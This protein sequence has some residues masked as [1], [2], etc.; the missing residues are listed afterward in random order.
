MKIKHKSKL[1]RISNALGYNRNLF[2]NKTPWVVKDIWSRIQSEIGIAISEIVYEQ[3]LNKLNMKYIK[4]STRQ[5]NFYQVKKKYN[6]R[7]R[8]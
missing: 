3:S 6:K 2:A 8:N 1:R 4:V 5:M 7:I